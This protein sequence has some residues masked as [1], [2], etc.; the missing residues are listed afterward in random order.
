MAGRNSKVYS[1][2]TIFLAIALVC[3]A[4]YSSAAAEGESEC[5]GKISERYEDSVEW[6][7]RTVPPAPEGA[8]NVLIILLDDVRNRKAVN[9]LLVPAARFAS[10][11]LSAV[12][13]VIAGDCILA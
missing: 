7:P 12:T 3:V 6:Y 1:V 5:K 9:F 2:R 10:V 8:P 11:L 13:V 4:G